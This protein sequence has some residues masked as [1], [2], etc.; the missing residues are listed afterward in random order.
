[1]LVPAQLVFNPDLARE[2]ALRLRPLDYRDA[3]FADIGLLFDLLEP[4]FV[5]F[6]LL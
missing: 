2:F 6:L 1:M 4:L 3:L 5:D